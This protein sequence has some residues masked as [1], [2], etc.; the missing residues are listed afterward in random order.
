MTPSLSKSR[1]DE[2]E[3]AFLGMTLARQIFGAIYSAVQ[4]RRETGL[5]RTEFGERAGRDKTGASKILKGPGNWTIQTI[6]D[7][8]N[9]LDLDVEFAFFDRK[10]PTTMFTGTGMHSTWSPSINYYGYDLSIGAESKLNMLHNLAPGLGAFLITQE[11]NSVT[12]IANSQVPTSAAGYTIP[13]SSIATSASSIWN[14]FTNDA[15]D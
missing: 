13:G 11:A 12:V 4:Y 2:N 9:A 14:Y 3:R 8:A 1:F 15:H 10:N 6:S 5:T 7:V